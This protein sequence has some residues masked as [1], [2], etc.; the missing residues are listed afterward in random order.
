M[1]IN[2]INPINMPWKSLTKYKLLILP[3]FLNIQDNTSLI[4]KATNNLRLSR[5]DTKIQ[6][7]IK[8]SLN[9][10]IFNSIIVKLIKHI[11]EGK[12]TLSISNEYKPSIIETLNATNSNRKLIVVKIPIFKLIHRNKIYIPTISLLIVP[13]HDKITILQELHT[14]QFL[15]WF[16]AR[17]FECCQQLVDYQIVFVV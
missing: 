8:S 5:T 10:L 13:Q 12:H 17:M 9:F 1:P 3:L 14:Y 16:L 2:T 11:N 7:A 6:N 15:L 4:I